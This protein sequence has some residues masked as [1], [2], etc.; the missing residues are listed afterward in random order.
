MTVK[1]GMEHRNY[2]KEN[3]ECYYSI[4]NTMANVKRQC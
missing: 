4:P 1:T 2:T 3:H